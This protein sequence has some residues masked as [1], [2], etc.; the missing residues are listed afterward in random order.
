MCVCVCVCVQYIWKA[1]HTITNHLLLI[2]VLMYQLPKTSVLPMSTHTEPPSLLVAP[3]SQHVALTMRAEF[4]CQGRGKPALTV[5]WYHNGRRLRSGKGI[6]I[7][8]GNEFCLIITCPVEYT[9]NRLHS[10]S[11]HASHWDN[12]LCQQRTSSYSDFLIN[13]IAYQVHP[14]FIRMSLLNETSH[15]YSSLACHPDLRLVVPFW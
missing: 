15:S 10:S 7:V 13:I 12:G 2:F 5:Q 8:N 14:C 4:T 3:T 6:I 9:V 11:K 1:F